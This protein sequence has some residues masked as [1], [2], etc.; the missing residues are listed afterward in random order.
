MS[1]LRRPSLSASV[2][3][4]IVFM[5]G[6]PSPQWLNAIGAQYSVDPEFYRRHLD[7]HAQTGRPDY[8]TMPPMPSEMNSII[9]LCVTTIG[10]VGDDHK[11]NRKSLE[12]RRETSARQME[13]YLSALR[14][15]NWSLGESLVRDFDIHD[16]SHWS[17][18]QRISLC[19][20]QNGNEW[21]GTYTL[22]RS[23]CS[24]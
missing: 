21:T 9:R 22:I 7:F 20:A 1:S 4:R 2:S 5:H 17:L 18:E 6:L 10:H 19:V 23:I 16:E 8:F 14:R 3:S 12:T 24:I 15:D 11:M 13:K